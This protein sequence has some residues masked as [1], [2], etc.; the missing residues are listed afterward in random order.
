MP[1]NT[2]DLAI[3]SLSVVGRVEFA[4]ILAGVG[5]T[6]VAMNADAQVGPV[7]VGGDWIASTIAAGVAPGTDG[8]Y[9][10]DDDEKFTGVM[11]DVAGLFSRLVSVAIA[12]QIVGTESPRD[13]ASLTAENVSA[14][15]IGG[16]PLV[17]NANLGADDFTI[18]LM[19]DFR[20]REV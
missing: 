7:T 1:T 20:V 17:L 12:S 10:T 14:V 11:K 19:G 4:Q 16:T 6:G 5:V 3:K 2:S 18:C 9:G 13:S 15:K 8:Y